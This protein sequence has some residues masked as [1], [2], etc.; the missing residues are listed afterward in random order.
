VGEDLADGDFVA[1]RKAWDILADCVVKVELA[2]FLKQEDG[3]GGELL[4]DGADRVAHVGRG[5]LV[6]A[7]VRESVSMRVDELAA[8]DDGD[9][10][11]GYSALLHDSGCDLVDAGLEGGVDCVYGLS[12]KRRRDCEYERAKRC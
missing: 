2:L 6:G 5:G 4:G 12:V 7:D 8:F 3:G 1:A 9:G 11:G 10:G